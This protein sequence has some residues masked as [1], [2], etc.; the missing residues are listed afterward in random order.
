MMLVEVHTV[1][2]H[3]ISARLSDYCVGVFDGLTTRKGI[4]KAIEKGCVF[5][6]GKPEGTG[7]FVKPGDQ[8]ELFDDQ[9]TAKIFEY[10]LDV[11]YEDDFLAVVD[12]PSGMLASGNAFRT[13]ENALPHNLKTENFRPQVAHR[14]DYPTRGLMVVG[15]TREVLIAL[16]KAFEEQ[17]IRKVYHALTIGEMPDNGVLSTDVDG[18]SAETVFDVVK[19]KASGKYGCF[20]LVRLVPKTGRRHQ[21]RVHLASIGYAILGDREYGKSIHWEM[22]KGLYLHAT[23]VSFEHPVNGNQLDITADLPRKFEKLMGN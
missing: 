12:K 5:V 7:F 16:K 9:N 22:K 15:K 21:I 13:L 17:R 10:E 3:T 19:S 11:L 14:L 1:P 18:K 23:E 20:N 8:I 6:N 2:E 4:K